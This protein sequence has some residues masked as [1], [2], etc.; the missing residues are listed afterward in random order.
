M[1]ADLTLNLPT[2]DRDFLVA[3]FNEHVPGVHVWAYGSRVSGRGHPG[4]DLDLVLR[5]DTGPISGKI[6][7]SLRDII[8]DSRLPFGVD[9]HDWSVL[10]PAFQAEIEKKHIVFV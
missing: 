5:L 4:S 3:L 7:G 10:P 9:L 6:L 2:A 1:S 8:K